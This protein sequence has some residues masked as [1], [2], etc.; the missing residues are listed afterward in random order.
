MKTL[1][2]AK[3][4]R[5]RSCESFWIEKPSLVS[6]EQYLDTEIPGWRQNYHEEN[7]PLSEQFEEKK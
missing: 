2:A 1:S 7:I 4:S 3:Y 6:F 5:V